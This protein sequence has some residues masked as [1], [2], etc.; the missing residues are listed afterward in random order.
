ML[1]LLWSRKSKV[2]VY[3]IIRLILYYRL[4]DLSAYAFK[5]Y[6]F[7]HHSTENLNL[8]DDKNETQIQIMHEVGFTYSISFKHIM[9]GVKCATTKSMPFSCNLMCCITRGEYTAHIFFYLVSRGK[10]WQKPCR[11]SDNNSYKWAYRLKPTIIQKG[12][13]LQQHFDAFDT[14]FR[15]L[16]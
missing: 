12:T 3:N 2:L 7:Y 1:E 10:A 6:N 8:F 14:L 4:R 15:S 11:T 5:N 16:N 13:N 9:N